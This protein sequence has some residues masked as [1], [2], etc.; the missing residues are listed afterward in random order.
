MVI[1]LELDFVDTSMFG[2]INNGLPVIGF[3]TVKYFRC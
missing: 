3:A 1:I 2:E